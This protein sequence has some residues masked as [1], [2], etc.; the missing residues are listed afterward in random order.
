LIE[1]LLLGK[2]WNEGNN[3]ATNGEYFRTTNC[4]IIGRSIRYETL[5]RFISWNYYIA[6]MLEIYIVN[7]SE[8]YKAKIY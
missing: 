6:N 5:L 3:N 7:I 2:T 8:D 1:E 4:Q